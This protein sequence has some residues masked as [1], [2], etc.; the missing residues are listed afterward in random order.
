MFYFLL[1]VSALICSLGFYVVI[2]DVNVLGLAPN[3]G[4]L[5]SV[6]GMCFMT[7][8]AIKSYPKTK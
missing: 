5:I 1:I 8:L 7:L 3:D 2:E 4:W 6:L